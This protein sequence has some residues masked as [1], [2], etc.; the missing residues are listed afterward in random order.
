MKLFN[1]FTI[2]AVC[3]VVGFSVFMG[4]VMMDSDDVAEPVLDVAPV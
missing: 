1:L 2:I 3:F 4:V